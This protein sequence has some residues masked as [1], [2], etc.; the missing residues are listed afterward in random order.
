MPEKSGAQLVEEARKIRPDLGWL[1]MSGYAGDIV[2][3]QK[4]L[5]NQV[6][7]AGETVYQA[8]ATRQSLCRLAHQASMTA[9]QQPSLLAAG[10]HTVGAEMPVRFIAFHSR[11]PRKY[12]HMPCS[13]Q[14]MVICR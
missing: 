9:A 1:L 10:S 13:R 4:G 14:I 8:F 11:S 12:C 2:G 5:T 6:T 3:P 7:P